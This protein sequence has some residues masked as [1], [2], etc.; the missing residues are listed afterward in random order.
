[1]LHQHTLYL[2]QVECSDVT[3][4]C[5]VYQLLLVHPV[6]LYYS[7]KFEVRYNMSE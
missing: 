2:V 3:R 7:M 1:M 5:C 6:T 4:Q